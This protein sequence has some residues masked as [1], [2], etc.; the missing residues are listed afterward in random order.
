MPN[1]AYYHPQLVHFAVVLCIVGVLLR[2]VSL[3]NKAPWTNPAAALF[4]I[5]GG[6]I[7]YFTAQ[8]GLDAH[9]PVEQ[10]PGVRDAVVEHED[11]GIR[12]RNAFGIIAVLELIAVLVRANI[13]KAL[14]LVTALGGLA[15][16]WVLYE[17][18]EH[19][20]E[21]VY[22]Y[23]GG[24]G[25]RSGNPEDLNRLLVAGLY[26]RAAADRKAGDFGGAA[27]LIDELAKRLPDDPSTKW[28]VLES[29]IKD[30]NDAAGALAELLAI[31]PAADDRRGTFRKAMLSADAYKA[32]GQIDSARAVLTALQ[33]KF[34]DARGIA[35]AIENLT[36]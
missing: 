12:A 23:A 13:G 26:T 25:L 29:R 30:R 17:A 3:T 34:P 35:T 28:L 4:L 15:G 11:W 27:R 33:L 6:V 32:L 7:A 8:S 21:L 31:S 36:K 2:L 9:G 24:P 10:I 16:L 19:G 5:A 14:R 18:A 20:G 22:E 1:I